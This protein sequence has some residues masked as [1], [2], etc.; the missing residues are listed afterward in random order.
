MLGNYF[1]SST[2]YGQKTARMS[3]KRALSSHLG[4]ENM[5][6]D[7]TLEKKNKNNI[8]NAHHNESHFILNF[9]HKLPQGHLQTYKHR[10]AL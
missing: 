3:M 2:F 1:Q 5:G 9:L 6:I 8:M 7:K 4:I 10:C